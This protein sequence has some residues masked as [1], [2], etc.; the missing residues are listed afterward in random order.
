MFFSSKEAFLKKIPLFENISERDVQLIAR[1]LKQ[2]PYKEGDLIFHE[3]DPGE[4]LFIVR[5]GKVRIYV[6]GNRS[7]V[8]TS[9][10]LFG[11]PGEVFGELAVVDG[12][13]RSASA[14]AIE[15]TVVYFVDR[16]TFRDH[17]LKIPQLAMNF[18]QLLTKRMRYNTSQLNSMAS[19]T[20]TSRLARQLIKLSNDYGRE[21][22]EGIVIDINLTQTDLASLIG[23]TRESTNRAMRSLRKAN[24]ADMIQGKLLVYNLAELQEIATASDSK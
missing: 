7:G 21:E 20:V 13:P 4:S 24:V 18:T 9:V 6:G 8:E 2:R 11:R 15:N 12:E 22:G 10:I 16:D 1:D 19:L 3:G 5:S 23:A 14:R 17:M